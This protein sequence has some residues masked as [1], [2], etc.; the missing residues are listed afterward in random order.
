MN[1]FIADEDWIYIN[2]PYAEAY[3]PEDIFGDPEK[4]SRVTAAE[5]GDGIQA[6]GIFRMRFFDDEDQPR[7]KAKLHTFCYPNM[8]ETY[9]TSYETVTLVIDNMEQKYRV[10]KY[11]QGDRMCRTTSTQDSEHVERYL[12]MLM[13]AKLPRSLKYDD[14]YKAWIDNYTSNGLMPPIPAVNLQMIVAEQCRDPKNP[15]TPFC[16]VIGKGG[17]S[18]YDY[19]PMNMNDVSAYSSIMAGLSFERLADKLTT[20]LN[21]TKQGVK[22]TKSP[23]EEVLSM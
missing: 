9:P 4:S 16:K 20:S 2:R 10:L 14:V 3:I 17:V 19:L 13:N 23:V 18:Q 11:Y 22:Q 6:I 5:Y 7:E 12:K 8:I 21:M 15:V 1:E